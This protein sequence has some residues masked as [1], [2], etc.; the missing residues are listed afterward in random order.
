MYY[1][2]VEFK[3]R[4]PFSTLT[5]SNF[6]C[7]LDHDN[8]RECYLRHV[9]RF[10][11]VAQ[12]GQRLAVAPSVAR[13]HRKQRHKYVLLLRLEDVLL[14]IETRQSRKL[15]IPQL[16]SGKTRHTAD[17]IFSE[18]PNPLPSFANNK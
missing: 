7:T 2:T 6:C 9:K 4:A 18:T 5:F 10:S 15:R 16:I 1:F 3:L 14:L 13:L 8:C 11:H 17:Q 12:L